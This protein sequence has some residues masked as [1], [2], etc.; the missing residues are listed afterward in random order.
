MED[1]ITSKVL[2]WITA[3]EQHAPEVI[4]GMLKMD[5]FSSYMALAVGIVLVIFSVFSFVAEYRFSQK[6]VSEAGWMVVGFISLLLGLLFI[7]PS[8]HEIY[9]IINE[10]QAYIVKEIL[11]R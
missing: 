10:P 4:Q 6:N 8:V 11:G 7:C 5:L 1:K 9:Y 3:G 2:E